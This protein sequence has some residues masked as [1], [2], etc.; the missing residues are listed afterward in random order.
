MQMN[1]FDHNSNYFNHRTANIYEQE[2]NEAM[3]K[4]ANSRHRLTAEDE[5][6]IKKIADKL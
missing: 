5:K 1:L 4:L 3:M 2:W 6:V